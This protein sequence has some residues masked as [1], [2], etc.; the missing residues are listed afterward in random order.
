MMDSESQWLSKQVVLD[1]K[2]KLL[3]TLGEKEEILTEFFL[4]PGT[5]Q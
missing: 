5:L 4:G 2:E 1:F 3:K